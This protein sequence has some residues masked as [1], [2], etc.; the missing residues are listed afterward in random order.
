MSANHPNPAPLRNLA[1]I[2]LGDRVYQLHFLLNLLADWLLD[3][4]HHDIS[5]RNQ[6]DLEYPDPPTIDDLPF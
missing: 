4:F 1:E 3:N 5:A 2:D 6:R